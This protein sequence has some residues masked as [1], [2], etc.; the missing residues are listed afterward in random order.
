LGDLR[1]FEFDDL[2]KQSILGW[3][4]DFRLVKRSLI[5]LSLM[6]SLLSYMVDPVWVA[7]F[8]L[9]A[10][11]VFRLTEKHDGDAYHVFD[12]LHFL[13]WLIS[14]IFLPMMSR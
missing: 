12:I 3:S 9:N 13:P 6:M 7:I 14:C 1:D 8:L 4:L 11:L 5:S 2:K 10:G